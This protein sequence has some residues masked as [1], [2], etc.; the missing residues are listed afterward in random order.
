[1]GSTGIGKGRKYFSIAQEI[2]PQQG[3][4]VPNSCIDWLCLAGAPHLKWQ[5]VAEGKAPGQL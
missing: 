3:S 1:M 5:I 4:G 2:R